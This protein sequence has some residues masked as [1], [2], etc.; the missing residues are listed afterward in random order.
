MGADRFSEI[1]ARIVRAAVESDEADGRRAAELATNPIGSG[2][3]E[4]ALS[5]VWE[6]EGLDGWCEVAVAHYPNVEPPSVGSGLHR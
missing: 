2:R 1:A 5:G 4:A 6:Y 3:P